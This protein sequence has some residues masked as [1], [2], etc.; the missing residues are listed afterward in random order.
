M[1]AFFGVLQNLH[2][3]VPVAVPGGPADQLARGAA[4]E[5]QKLHPVFLE[6]VQ[7]PGDGGVL[8]GFCLPEG[9]PADVDVQAATAGLVTAVAHLH[10]GTAQRGPG[11]L[12]EMVVQGHG[13]GDDFEAVVRGTVVLAV[14]VLRAVVDQGH[15]G[16]SG[17][18]ALAAL[19]DLQLHAEVAG[20]GA[21]EDGLGLVVIALNAAGDSIAVVVAGVTQRF[22]LVRV[23]GFIVGI[24]Q[25]NQR[26]AVVAACVVEVIAVLAEGRFHGPGV[27]VPPE[28]AAA[29]GTADGLRFQAARAEG[30][31]VKFNAVGFRDSL[32]ADFT[33]GEIEVHKQW[34]LSK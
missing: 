4:G 3:L 29:V 23:S 12:V 18:D 11:H 25:G 33:E 9:I 13:M 22:I 30:L 7:G 1:D 5:F 15:Q 8:V 34:L 14:D 6:E 31:A 17:A 20:T 10:R 32:S 27:V 24:G 16:L 19:V 28:T 26:A 2:G 21:V